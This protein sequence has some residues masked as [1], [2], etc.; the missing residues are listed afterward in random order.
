ML[1]SVASDDPP[2]Q[3]NNSKSDY[4]NEAQGSPTIVIPSDK[5]CGT[6]TPPS[7]GRGAS[8]FA[9]S[10]LGVTLWFRRGRQNRG[11][12]VVDPSLRIGTD[13]FERMSPRASPRSVSGIGIGNLQLPTT[14]RMGGPQRRMPNAIENIT[15]ATAREK[16]GQVRTSTTGSLTEIWVIVARCVT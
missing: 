10:T 7:S 8:S 3:A 4:R 5:S 12:L 14:F 1:S 9:F 6:P 2:I 13:I 16:S 15:T 11:C